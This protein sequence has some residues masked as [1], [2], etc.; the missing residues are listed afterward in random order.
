M[1]HQGAARTGAPVLTSRPG[2]AAW[3]VLGLLAGCAGSPSARPPASP[4]GPDAR[5]LL[6]RVADRTLLDF[7]SPPPFDWG[8]GVL[9]SGMARAGR[10]SGDPR[11]ADF[12]RRWAGHWRAR[13]LGP[14]L[15]EKGYCGH[16][17]PAHALLTLPEE[18]GDTASRDM[19]REVVAYIL[20]EGTRSGDGGLGHWRGNP[21]LWIDTLYM[22]APLLAALGVRDSRPDLVEEAVKQVEVFTARLRDERTGLFFHMFDERD[23]RRTEE[24]W[25]RGNGWAA[26][27]LVEVL[28]V[29]D[30]RS[31]RFERLA[32]DLRRLAEALLTLQDPESGLWRTVLDRPDTDPE[33]SASAMFLYALLEGRKL[34][35][36][37]V[38]EEPIRR[39]WEGLSRRVDADGRVTGVSAG[40]RPSDRKG[41][42]AIPQGTFPWGTGAFLLA[43]SALAEE[44]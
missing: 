43:A 8:E 24:L 17:G 42:A 4:P 6:A 21:Q 32:G 2:K 16:W 29:L 19:A 28:R 27:S 38:G 10:A 41:Y 26:M 44:G 18:A 35:L 13:G 40:T 36:L 20:A 31:P 30:R 34:G 25:A 5:A 11:Y 7:P 14:V 37:A 12:V 15:R 1:C 3:I 23:G 39:A 9:M 22:S 33:A